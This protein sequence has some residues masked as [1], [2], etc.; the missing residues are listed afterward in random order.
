MG[1]DTPRD[2]IFNPDSMT[3]TQLDGIKLWI[4]GMNNWYNNK[5]CHEC[6]H[7]MESFNYTP[8]VDT[9][10]MSVTLIAESNN[11]PQ[12]QYVMKK[13]GEDF[14]VKVD[15][16]EGMY[17]YRFYVDTMLITDS[18]AKVNNVFKNGD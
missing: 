16:R 3:A 8:H 4:P 6:A 2:N 11:W 17:Y 5:R 18:V 12:K 7:H 1:I 14:E 13:T 10:S 15:L 9:D